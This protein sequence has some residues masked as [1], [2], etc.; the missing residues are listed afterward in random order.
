MLCQAESSAII[1]AAHQ[2]NR[3]QVELERVFGSRE[4]DIDREKSPG[5]KSRRVGLF[6][7]GE[8]FS[9]LTDQLGIV[10]PLV[11]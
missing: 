2:I 9:H 5:E 7:R 4:S 1:R 3:G 8:P 11:L 10:N 6:G